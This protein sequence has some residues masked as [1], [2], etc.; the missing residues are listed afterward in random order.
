MPSTNH[1]MRFLEFIIHLGPNWNNFVVQ[2]PSI[3][4][5][6]NMISLEPKMFCVVNGVQS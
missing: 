6:I 2:N 5:K 4:G 1:S 3:F